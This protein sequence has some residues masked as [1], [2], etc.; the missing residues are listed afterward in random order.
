MGRSSRFARP[1]RLSL[2][3]VV[4]ERDGE[5]VYVSMVVVIVCYSCDVIVFG[6]LIDDEE[7][8][9]RRMDAPCRCDLFFSFRFI[10]CALCRKETHGTKR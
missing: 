3:K 10:L 2:R 9:V 7:K 1:I 5:E 8:R 6:L 4:R